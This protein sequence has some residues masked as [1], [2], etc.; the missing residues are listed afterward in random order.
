MLIDLSSYRVL[1]IIQIFQSLS[2]FYTSRDFSLRFTKHCLRFIAAEIKSR[3]IILRV[4]F[5]RF[6]FHNSCYFSPWF[7]IK[8]IN[9][10]VFTS[11]S[12]FY[13]KYYLFSRGIP[14]STTQYFPPFSPIKYSSYCY[15]YPQLFHSNFIPL[16]Y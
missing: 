10:P 2:L 1:C 5:P 8:F 12:P 11:F 3:M 13:T 14:R 15:S 4:R 7:C 16:Q 9:L 6:P